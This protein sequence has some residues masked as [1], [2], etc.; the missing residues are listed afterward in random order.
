[1]KKRFYIPAIL[2]AII[3]ASIF[4]HFKMNYLYLP[5]AGPDHNLK[6]YDYQDFPE[7]LFLLI[8]KRV[9]GEDTKAY[10]VEDKEFIKHVIRIVDE[11]EEKPFME[12]YPFQNI[13]E[14]GDRYQVSVLTQEQGHKVQFTFYENSS[15]FDFS[16]VYFYELKS[17]L[18]DQLS[19]LAS[20]ENEVERGHYNRLF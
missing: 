12:R 13:Q 8:E 10:R 14:A 9:H 11:A 15:I 16:G 7:P 5:N 19:Q 20:E 2:L 3:V 17:D 1:M 4:L 6:F 18:K